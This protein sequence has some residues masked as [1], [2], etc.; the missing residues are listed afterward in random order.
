[1]KK[2]AELRLVSDDSSASEFSPA[3]APRVRAK[4][5][6]ATL[7][8]LRPRTKPY[9]VADERGLFLLVQPN[10]GRWW[11]FRYTLNG[12]EK[13]ISFGS[14]P[15]VALKEARDRRDEARKHVAA[16]IDP[17]ALRRK[18]RLDRAETFEAIARDWH[19]NRRAQWSDGTAETKLRRLEMHV[20]PKLGSL[21]IRD[22]SP[23]DVLT[24]LRRVEIGGRHDTAHRVHQLIGE[25]F[26]FAIATGRA[27]SD[28]SRDL[29]GAL[30]PVIIENRAAPEDPASKRGQQKVA[31]L[32]RM[33]DE[34]TGFIATRC[35]LR[36]APLVFVRPGEL[37]K[38]EWS[39]IDFDSAQ[40]TIPAEKMKM[41]Q[42]LI[43][44]LSRQAIAIL[45]EIQPVT[46]DGRYVF[47][48]GRSGDRP[49]SDNAIL[50]A[51][52]R[53]GIAKDEMTGHGWRAV[54]RTILDEVLGWRVDIIE[55]QLG[56]TVKDPNGRAYNRTQFLSE[57]VKLMQQWADHLD[58]LREAS[59]RP[60]MD[61][62]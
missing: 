12:K 40:W 30:A 28:V 16:G 42:A 13:L 27:D 6:D 17:S 23:P 25:V 43:V 34:Y 1:M 46:G 5:T 33:C 15:D 2:A 4:L 39:E 21:P 55:H 50:A 59:M 45:R 18:E 26:R 58:Q 14:Y 44:P 19:S 29:R 62:R 35:A 51:M 20:F 36:L 48:S 52:R 11:R 31:A 38:A 53:M 24:V 10:G 47:P 54:A 49:M 56:H 7:R 41:R 32:L 3:A 60:G 9:K 57:R 37:R 22:I 61:N 8:S